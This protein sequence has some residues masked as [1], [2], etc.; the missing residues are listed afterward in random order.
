M[1]TTLLRSLATTFDERGLCNRDRTLHYLEHARSF[2]IPLRLVAGT[3]D[4]QVSVEAV[5]RTAAQVGGPAEAVILGR[6]HGQLDDYG[7]WDLVLGKRAPS[8]VWP[9][10]LSWLESHRNP[11]TADAPGSMLLH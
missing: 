1:P 11:R 10:V 9:H 3:V 6:R 8:E 7:H 4:A 5:E 2:R